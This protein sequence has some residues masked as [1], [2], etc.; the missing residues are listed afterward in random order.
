MHFGKPDAPPLSASGSLLA[1]EAAGVLDG[2]HVA[3]YELSTVRTCHCLPPAIEAGDATPQAVNVKDGRS[4]VAAHM[5][6]C[7]VWRSIFPPVVS[8]PVHRLA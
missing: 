1:F 8:F 7:Y 3:S 4:V 5:A 6:L 2:L